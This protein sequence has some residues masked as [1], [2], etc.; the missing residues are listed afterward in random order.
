MLGVVNNFACCRVAQQRGLVLN[1]NIKNNGLEG[2]FY[3]QR[4]SGS[5][6]NQRK[7]ITSR[8]ATFF[9]ANLKIGIARHVEEDTVHRFV[10]EY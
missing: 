1:L 5:H 9:L 4:E 3:L 10:G 6:S 7:L 2:S 8:S